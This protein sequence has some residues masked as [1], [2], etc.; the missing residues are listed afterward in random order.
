MHIDLFP[1]SSALLCLAAIA[2]P[3]APT[4]DQPLYSE[5]ERAA[6]VSYWNAPG[7]YAVSLVKEANQAGPYEVRLSAEGSKWFY[8]YQKAVFGSAKPTVDARPSLSGP[9]G[10]WEEWVGTKLAFDR[11][12]AQQKADSANGVRPYTDGVQPAANTSL[13]P[14]APGPMPEGLHAVCGDAPMLAETVAPRRYR[15]AFDKSE[16]FTYTDHVQMR[17]RY[18]YYRFP[19]GVV[20]YGTRL[21]QMPQAERDALFTSAGFTPAEQRIFSAVSRLEG[22]FETVQTYDSGYVS[23]GFI[24]FVTLEDGKADL[25]NVLLQMKTANPKAFREDFRRFGIDIHADRTLVVVDPATGAELTGSN[26]V[27][28]IIEDKRLT[29]VFQRAGRRTPF[30]IAQIK[31]ARSYYWPTHDALTVTLPNGTSVTGTIGDVVKSEAG[32]ATLLDRKI[33]IGNINQFPSV[34]QGV[35]NAHGCK[36]LAEVAQYEREII[37][38]MTY[39]ENFLADAQLGQPTL[40]TTLPTAMPSPAPLASPMP[41]Q[42][43]LPGLIASPES[44]PSLVPTHTN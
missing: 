1:Y 14:P 32:L 20:S 44:T 31:T 8:A 11:W 4:V 25:S 30:R 43:R 42:F 23:I 7:R 37:A 6:I 15:I 27:M 26:A 39:R 13:A 16:E 10:S 35:I 21:S 34:V 24:Q 9:Y 40:P 17:D 5:K 12:Q 3:Q 38:S 33:N 19:Q 41:V 29:A 22:G 18:A 36:S 28:R 2:A